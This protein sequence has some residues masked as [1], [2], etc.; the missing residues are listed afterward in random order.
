MHVFE[1]ALLHLPRNS[2]TYYLETHIVDWGLSVSDFCLQ[3]YYVHWL[4]MLTKL[5]LTDCCKHC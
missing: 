1:I 4:F 3:H 2:T 5:L